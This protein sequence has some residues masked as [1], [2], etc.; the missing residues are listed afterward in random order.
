MRTA[1]ATI[2][3]MAV[4][5]ASADITLQLTPGSLGAHRQELASASGKVT[6]KGTLEAADFDALGVLPDEVTILDMSDIAIQGSSSRRPDAYGR[7]FHP[8]NRIPDHAFFQSNV[9][10]VV[11]PAKCDLG[12][13]AFAE[14]S[15]RKVT[16]PKNTTAI[17][18]HA[19][20]RS[21]VK[22][23]ANADKVRWIG[24]EAFT[25][26]AM[27]TLSFPA[28]SQASDFAM[29]GMPELTEVRVARNARLGKGVFMD[30]PKLER[31]HGGVG[32]LPDYFTANSSSVSIPDNVS[33]I[34]E[35]A[36][37]NSSAETM[38]FGEG[39]SSIGEG[40]FMGM[41]S[42]RE[43]NAFYCE[44][45]V[46]AVALGSFQGLNV[47]AIRLLVA[48]GCASLWKGHEVWGKFDV[49]DDPAAVDELAF[50]DS[51]ISI[52]L[53]EGMVEIESAHPISCVEVFDQS[54]FR[55]Y[56]ESPASMRHSF[57]VSVI[58]G[59]GAALVRVTTGK[60]CRVVKIML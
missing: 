34:G 53:R 36:F 22:E 29:A 26:C 21:A 5:A 3:A 32:I 17:P 39:L 16:L 24:K 47:A 15:T 19:F 54:G 50:D 48:P 33:D 11:L 30:C 42:L 23:I 52:S 41:S 49:V 25:G 44:Q 43:I 45:Q 51:G 31:I 59:H 20:Y 46:P 27:E 35:Y 57:P 9:R 58:D 14:A 40:A 56:R 60:G 8:D 12:E 13:A 7:H 1:T 18:D 38:A 6:L 55:T 2:A 10:E 37:A 4:F 28:L